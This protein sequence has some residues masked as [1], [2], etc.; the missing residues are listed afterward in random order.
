MSNKQ[1]NLLPKGIRKTTY[2]TKGQQKEGNNKDQRGYK[3]GI[4]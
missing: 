2:K 1:P 3:I 4:K